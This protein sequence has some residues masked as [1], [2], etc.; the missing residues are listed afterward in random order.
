[1]VFSF[2]LLLQAGTSTTSWTSVDELSFKLRVLIPIVWSSGSCLCLF[3]GC[4][5]IFS[6]SL[7]SKKSNAANWLFLTFLCLF[8]IYVV[9]WKE[10]WSGKTQYL[11]TSFAQKLLQGNKSYSQVICD[12]GWF[13]IGYVL[14]SFL[15][16]VEQVTTPKEFI[17]YC[18]FL[19]LNH[20]YR[21]CN[22]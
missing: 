12:V 21:V 9:W 15:I 5:T 10:V 2:D 22:G 17:I 3:D 16:S 11:P 20:L 18:L 13:G 19:D 1:M 8:I 14:E 4:K 6:F 7:H